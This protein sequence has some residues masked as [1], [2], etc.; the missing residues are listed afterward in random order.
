MVRLNLHPNP[1]QSPPDQVRGM[2]FVK[3]GSFFSSFPHV[4]SGNLRKG[5]E[6]WMPASAGMTDRGQNDS[7]FSQRDV[8]Q[9]GGPSVSPSFDE[10]STGFW[11]KHARSL[12][13]GGVRGD[14]STNNREKTFCA[15]RLALSLLAASL[16]A[17]LAGCT[18]GPNYVRPTVTIPAG[19][20][21]MDGWKIAQPKDDVIRG[22]WWEMFGDPQLNALEAQ[23]S[24]SNQNLAAAE[25]QY[26]EARALVR[27]ARAAYYPT[28]TIGF[29]ANRSSPSTTTGSGPASPRVT[30]SDDSLPLDISWEIDVW[31]RIRRSVE[32]NEASA[33]ASAADVESARLSAQAA[34][35]QDYFQLRELDAQK[36]LL[37]ETVAA[38]QKSLEL[39]QGLYAQGVDSE[40]DV[41]QAETQLKTTEAQLINVGVQRAQ[42][43]HAIAVLIGK[44]ASEF[45]IPV[46]PLE[47]TPPEIPVGV[48][49]ELLERRPDIAVSERLV[50]AQNAQIGVAEAA[51]YPTVTLSAS[52][53]SD[54][55]SLGK[56]FSAA[57]R[58]WSVGA[59]ISET[60]FDGGLRRA[61][62]DFARAAY[63]S[64]VAT[65]RQTVLTA[66]QGVEDN[67]AALRILEQEAGVQDEA[68]KAAGRSVFLTLNQYQAGTVS[69]LNVITAQTIALTDELTAI[70][71]RGQRMTAAVLL[72]QALGGGWNVSQLP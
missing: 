55:S 27:E 16:L 2:L 39:T 13:K 68:V 34:L 49:S 32:S 56:L 33:Q 40:V 9:W 61:Q 42:L 46:K 22:A 18:V 6:D 38:F 66:F 58:F 54:S 28:A 11:K 36:Q 31:G 53:G 21:E 50:A 62:T 44:P 1:P 43:E 57:S 24:I 52:L 48:P 60:V 37:T 10:P 63:D 26:R 51:F 70:Q 47:G 17:V 72:V 71:I 59:S 69:Y 3:G 23:V 8:C 45:S 20:R 65:Y 19:Y 4:F 35:A 14:F 25:A 30:V 29:G 41:V 5:K 7:N 67:L 64:S 15:L 12:S